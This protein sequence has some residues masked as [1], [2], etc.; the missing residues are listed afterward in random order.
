[1]AYPLPSLAT[2]NALG[3]K[4][5]VDGIRTAL[6][7]IGSVIIRGDFAKRLL[8]PLPL[9]ILV[10]E[11]RLELGPV[12]ACLFGKVKSVGIKAKPLYFAPPPSGSVAYVATDFRPI[13]LLPK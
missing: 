9:E 11:D 2:I 5:P 13:R 8:A 6:Q 10:N 7:L 1:L 12:C 3:A 4:G